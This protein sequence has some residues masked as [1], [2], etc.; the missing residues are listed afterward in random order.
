MVQVTRYPG[1]AHPERGEC[2]GASPS[3]QTLRTLGETQRH[4][5][6][7]PEATSPP[8]QLPPSFQA[9]HHPSWVLPD[10]REEEE[11]E[12]EAGAGSRSGRAEQVAGATGGRDP[13]NQG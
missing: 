13:M 2:A 7:T 5:T 6:G 3:T 9:W 4:S 12:G 8:L 1:R 10:R 11:R